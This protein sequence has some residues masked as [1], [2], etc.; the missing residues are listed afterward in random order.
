MNEEIKKNNQNQVQ[1]IVPTGNEWR[2]LKNWNE[3]KYFT[4]FA[5]KKIKL[6]FYNILKKDFHDLPFGA[7]IAHEKIIESTYIYLYIET[8]SH[9]NERKI[10]DNSYIDKKKK[11]IVKCWAIGKNEKFIFVLLFF[12][13]IYVLFSV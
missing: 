8:D 6:F 12:I 10:S 2:A 13:L 7:S 3:T 11:R 4:R 1:F 9:T 5:M